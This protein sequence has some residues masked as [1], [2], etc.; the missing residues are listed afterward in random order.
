MKLNGL[1]QDMERKYKRKNRLAERLRKTYES[2]VE[3]KNT[4]TFMLFPVSYQRLPCQLLYVVQPARSSK[5][6]LETAR[7]HARARCSLPP[8]VCSDFEEDR[9]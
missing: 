7:A 6:L 8:V 2:N 5:C 9:E 1:V 4:L 3:K